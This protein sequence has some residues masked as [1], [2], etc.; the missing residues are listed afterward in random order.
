[1]SNSRRTPHLREI[2]EYLAK[3][4]LPA[5]EKKARQLVLGS[6][7]FT[8]N[9]GVLYKVEPDKSLRII[10]PTLDRQKLF[11]EAHG[12]PFS[13]HLREAK[14]HSELSRHY[15]WPGMRGDIAS[16][17]RSCLTCAAQSVG[18]P[19]QPPLTPIPVDGP[20]D[21]MGVDVLQLPKTR[22]RN[23]YAVVF[24][25]YL[26]KWP[27]VYATRDQTAPTIAKLLVERII[28]RHGVPRQL[29][30]DRGPSFL[31]KLML[32]VCSVMGIKKVNTTAYHPQTDGLIERFN[33]TLVDMLAKTVKA[34]V[35]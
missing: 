29:L 27:E 1:M 2:I 5:E 19:V 24:M 4:D 21:R 16:M 18:K 12:G 17:C 13:G 22:R 3:G 7:Q 9:N 10:P 34:G 15:W 30:S 31:S 35:E 6:S 20:F 28:S 14:I 33:R 11:E 8:L 25:D 32:E 26:T 23:R